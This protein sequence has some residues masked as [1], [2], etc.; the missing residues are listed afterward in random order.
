M[1]I[2]AVDRA[3]QTI[4]LDPL[5]ASTIRTV[6][7][8]FST[9]AN[10]PSSAICFMPRVQ[11][12]YSRSRFASAKISSRSEDKIDFRFGFSIESYAKIKY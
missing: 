7:T 1:L 4:H 5:L 12:K 9:A 3:V 8:V 11:A 10:F 6:T 2:R